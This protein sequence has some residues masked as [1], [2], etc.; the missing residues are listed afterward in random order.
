[1][2]ALCPWSRPVRQISAS[3]R[4]SADSRQLRGLIVDA[5][6]RGAEQAELDSVT[7][8]PLQAVRGL[9]VGDSLVPETGHCCPDAVHS[10][11]S[12]RPRNSS[13]PPRRSSRRL[14]AGVAGDRQLR[15]RGTGRGRVRDVRQSCGLADSFCGYIQRS[16]QWLDE[17]LGDRAVVSAAGHVLER[18]G[19]NDPARPLRRL[20]GSSVQFPQPP[21]HQLPQ[22]VGH[23]Y[24]L[25]P[26]G[27]GRQEPGGGWRRESAAA[28]AGVGEPVDGLA[29][30]GACPHPGGP[31]QVRLPLPRSVTAAR[32]FA[33]DVAARLPMTC[34]PLLR[35]GTDRGPARPPR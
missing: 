7:T 6:L 21:S 12:G 29:A 18:P 5:Q 9:H 25:G 3:T 24:T 17:A 28:V 13:P 27:A 2:S 30:A 11:C 32:R 16:C 33:L 8:H 26:V 22:V 23:N 14:L 19:G 20:L 31:T 4:R 35:G 10:C 1:V 15:D 34:V